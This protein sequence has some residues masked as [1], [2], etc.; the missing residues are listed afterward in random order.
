MAIVVSKSIVPVF[1]YS[2]TNKNFVDNHNH[3]LSLVNLLFANQAS[4]LIE[5]TGTFSVSNGTTTTVLSNNLTKNITDT[6]AIIFDNIEL[7][8]SSTK[9]WIH[10]QTLNIPI[11][12]IGTSGSKYIYINSAADVIIVNAPYTELTPNLV[13]LAKVSFNSSN[14]VHSIVLMPEIN[15]TSRLLRSFM[16]NYKLLQVKDTVVSPITG[17]KTLKRTNTKLFA[18]GIGSLD[19][20]KVHTLS[21]SDDQPVSLLYVDQYGAMPA[22]FAYTTTFDTTTYLPIL[23]SNPTPTGKCAVC[24]LNIAPDGTLVVQHG[25]KVYNTISDASINMINEHFAGIVGD[26]AGEYVP[27][28]RI[29]YKHAATDLANAKQAVIISLLVDQPTDLMWSNF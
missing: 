6:T 7:Y 23:T 11:V 25:V 4:G 19:S 28:A 5:G 9:S 17:T 21:I 13:R 12:D 29:A 18:E 1:D 22:S 16:Y 26:S 24:Q 20:N 10:V 2:D 3:T 8:F 27:V 14:Q 15:S